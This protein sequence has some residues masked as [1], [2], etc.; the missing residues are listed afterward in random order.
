[1]YSI[2]ANVPKYCIGCKH[3]SYERGKIMTWFGSHPG[4]HCLSTS[5]KNA[6]TDN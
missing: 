3:V 4:V 6:I 5:L 2:H 1:M